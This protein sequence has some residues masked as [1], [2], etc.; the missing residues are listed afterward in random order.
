MRDK[1]GPAFVAVS[2]VLAAVLLPATG[3]RV[4]WRIILVLVFAGTAYVVPA[5]AA[6][7]PVSSV[8]Q[9]LRSRFCAPVSFISHRGDSGLVD[10]G[11]MGTSV[12]E[13]L[14]SIARRT[15]SYRLETIDGRLVLYS[16]EPEFGREMEGVKIKG[17]SRAQAADAYVDL[18]R[19]RKLFPDLLSVPIVGDDRA[20]VYNEKVELRKRGRV[21]DQLIDLLGK[22]TSLYLEVLTAPS[23]HPYVLLG[24]LACK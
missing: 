14:G 21:I 16:T 3:L 17:V 22:D 2:L 15:G 11:N 4:T 18:L 10:D 7:R 1:R 13:A 5:S 20:A 12:E 9:D 23:G 19:A 24:Q 6:K 8:V